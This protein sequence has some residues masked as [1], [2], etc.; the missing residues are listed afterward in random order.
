[1]RMTLQ[2]IS[3]LTYVFIG[4]MLGIIV[5]GVM[6]TMM[7]T[8]RE[9][10]REIGTLRAI[11]MRRLWVLGMFVIEAAVLS[12]TAA[13]SGSLLG[14][15]LVVVLDAAQLH[16][17]DAFQL[18]LM[19]DTLKLTLDGE[20]AVVAVVVIGVVTTLA[21]VFPSWRAAKKPPVTA[22]QHV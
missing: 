4:I 13:A 21:S 15:V 22:I 16:V 10:T 11:G 7:M 17:S 5:I 20:T 14:A 19:S 1:M 2:T 12:F 9:R 8:I 6:N 3:L 18:F